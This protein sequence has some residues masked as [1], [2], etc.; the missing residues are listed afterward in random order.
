MLTVVE[1][2]PLFDG[3]A[4]RLCVLPNP[5]VPCGDS[6]QRWRLAK[7]L[8]CRKMQRIERANGFDGKRPTNAGEDRV[9]HVNKVAA[10]LKS[11]QSPDC[12]SFLLG[13]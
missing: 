13:R 4:E 5:S 9:R 10:T 11:T 1:L 7:Q 8:D 3:V 12:C 2:L 6:H